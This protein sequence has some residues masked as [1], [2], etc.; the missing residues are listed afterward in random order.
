[1]NY[2]D[3]SRSKAL[4]NIPHKKLE[5]KISQIEK[6]EDSHQVKAVKLTAIHRYAE[7]NI[8]FEYW[9]LKMEKDFH[10]NQRLLDVYNQV[11][12]D[13]KESYVKGSSF[14]F[15]GTHGVGK[16]FV[17]ASILKKAVNKGFSGL[18]TT[19]SDIVSALTQADN[20]EKFLARRELCMVDFLVIDEFDPRFMATENAADLYARTLETVF[21]T[22]SQNKLPTIMCT[23]S[24]NVVESFSGSLKASVGS[25][26]SGYLK[27]VPV[28]GEDFRKR[29]KE[30]V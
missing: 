13:V 1:M 18:Y 6:S 5:D 15:A 10:G 28:I 16:T 29:A 20:E 3:F 19:L 26:V 12:E 23:N 9:N 24:P 8:P 2:Q 27:I 30:N 11:T 7:T 21:R 14:C 22:R 4:N 17:S 25:L